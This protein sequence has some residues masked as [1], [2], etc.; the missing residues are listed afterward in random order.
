MSSIPQLDLPSQTRRCSQ[1][2]PMSCRYRLDHVYIP[3]SN[4]KEVQDFL[5]NCADGFENSKLE[6]AHHPTMHLINRRRVLKPRYNA[7][8]YA[9]QTQRNDLNSRQMPKQYQQ[10]SR[11]PLPPMYEEESPN[12]EFQEYDVQSPNIFQ[13]EYNENNLISKPQSIRIR[14]Y[15]RN[16]MIQNHSPEEPSEDQQINNDAI[17]QDLPLPPYEEYNENPCEDIDEK[18]ID[19][20]AEYTESIN[21]NVENNIQ[22]N[23]LANQ[24]DY[25]ENVNADGGNQVDDINNGNSNVENDDAH[26]ENDDQ[27]AEAELQNENLNKN[28]E[29]LNN[30]ANNEEVSNGVDD[31]NAN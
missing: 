2:L 17:D 24:S 3:A 1:R 25:T 23:E 20:A 6:A 13:S 9:T 28:N 26:V 14:M 10:T 18:E 11:K 29:N 21:M 7:G 12:Y 31:T 16:E 15:H 19:Q 4:Q 22:E 27:N 30:D 8:R 5:T